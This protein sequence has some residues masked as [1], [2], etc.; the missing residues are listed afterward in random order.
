[1]SDCIL[2]DKKIDNKG[3]GITWIKGKKFWAH[4][5]A[6][7][8]KYGIEVEDIRGL[9]FHHTCDNL[10]CIN[11]DHIYATKL[12]INRGEQHGRTNLKDK[13]V[14]EIRRRYKP[15]CPVNGQ[16]ALAREFNTSERTI[17]RIVKRL[18]WKHIQ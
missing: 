13:D 10:S 14:V 5:I 11:P 17:R 9:S 4:A 7:C 12:Q 1:M 6:Y 16:V 3:R 8:R 2:W 18:S 15:W